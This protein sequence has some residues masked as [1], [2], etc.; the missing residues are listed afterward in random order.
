LRRP[1]SPGAVRW[2]VQSTSGN[3][4]LVVG[5]IDARLVVE[6]LNLVC[7]HLWHDEYED[8]TGNVLLCRLTIDGITRCDVGEAKGLG[9]AIYSDALKRAAVKFGIG[10]SLYAM[11][12][13]WLTAGEHLTQ[14]EVRGKTVTTITPDGDTHLR[15]L[16]SAWLDLERGGQV[17]GRYLDHGDA[18]EGSVGGLVEQETAPAEPEQQSF[19]DTKRLAEQK[20]EAQSLYNGLPNNG[21]RRKLTKASFEAQ[22]Q[23]CE[24][25]DD[26]EELIARVKELAK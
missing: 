6:R 23:A 25:N 16:Y 3:R 7:P 17:F 12:A 20:A 8:L 19:V 18:E 22:L 14:R 26:A 9:K 13:I 11:R 10:V 2:K 5:Y 4:G 15:G 24:S 1:F 21:A